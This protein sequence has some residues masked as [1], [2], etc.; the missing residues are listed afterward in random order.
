MTASRTIARNIVW[1]WA[2]TATQMLA[3]FVVAPFLVKTLGDT[4]YGL[5]ILI[6]SL[7]G[8]FD[9]LDFG[10]RASLGRTIALHRSQQN[11]AEAT[12]AISTG[13]AVLC[14]QAMFVLGGTLFVV[15]AYFRIFDVPPEQATS[16]KIALSLVAANLAAIYLFAVFDAVLWAEQRFDLLNGVDIPSVLCRMVLTFA[17]V[18]S[19]DSLVRLAA[20][21]LA[22][23]VASGIAKTLV[24]WRTDPKFKLSVASVCRDSSRQ[25]FSFGVWCFLTTIARMATTQLGPLFIGARL[26]VALVTPYSIAQRLVT[27]AKSLVVVTTGVFTPYST[28]LHA[29]ERSADQRRLFLAG[30]K[31]CLLLSCFFAGYFIVLGEPLL[32]LWIGER[33]RPYWTLLMILAVGEVLP[34][35]Q[36][37]SESLLLAMGRHRALALLGGAE[38]AGI[39]ILLATLAD[40]YGILGVSI[41]FAVPA[42]L[43]RGIAS[44]LVAC[45]MVG[46]SPRDYLSSAVLPVFF[47]VA[48][49]VAVLFLAARSM[50]IDA[51]PRLIAASAVYTSAYFICA[52]LCLG[53]IAALRH[54]AAGNFRS[55]LRF[56][57]H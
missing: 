24:V 7:T 6:A 43:T 9:V 30:G 32:V 35:S 38:L 12:R 25:L 49:L 53:G 21:S 46:V 19:G 42:A 51:W 39:A 10:L 54:V 36:G 57:A 3:G 8:Y 47:V 45:R 2:G 44:M 14:G 4:G 31:M 40:R 18:G 15:F 48:P 50:E 27:Y 26:T 5:W 56:E 16:A 52:L 28:A 33:M 11:D 55:L 17:I 22:L 37:I 41:A 23:T 1:N 34:M 13:F 29:T 20:I